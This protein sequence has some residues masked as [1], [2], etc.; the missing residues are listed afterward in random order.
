MVLLA[1]TPIAAA[2]DPTCQ[3]VQNDVQQENDHDCDPYTDHEAYWTHR[4]ALAF[5]V[6]A[7]AVHFKSPRLFEHVA[8]RTAQVCC[9][10]PLKL[11]MRMFFL[12]D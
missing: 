10:H 3:A 2:A 4:D 5:V 7:Q 12:E 1:T 9:F 6:A 11:S 8:V